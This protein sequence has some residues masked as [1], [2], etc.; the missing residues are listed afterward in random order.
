MFSVEFKPVIP[1]IE[2]PHTHASDRTTTGI[3]TELT[4]NSNILM[5]AK[6]IYI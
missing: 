4:Y 6:L 1:A 5:Y 2:G 3:E